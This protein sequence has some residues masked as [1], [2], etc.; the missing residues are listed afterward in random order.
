MQKI[1][2]WY[3][4]K[5]EQH[6]VKY[7]KRDDDYQ[8]KSRTKALSYVQNFRVAIDIGAHVGLWSRDLSK[9]FKYIYSF[10]PMFSHRECFRQNLLSSKY[11]NVYLLDWAIG[12]EDKKV[13]FS[14]DVKST[15]STHILEG[16]TGTVSA[17]MTTLDRLSYERHYLKD[18]QEIDFIKLDCE[19]YEY[20]ALQGAETVIKKCRP[21]ICVEYKEKFKKRFPETNPFLLLESWGMIALDKTGDDHIWGWESP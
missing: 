10:E 5:E 2:S 6:L 18:F 19:G 13:C 12:N 20:Y 3:L 9:A 11:K 8:K 16:S 17:D 4:P 15:G 21:V 1:K 7:I 14:Y